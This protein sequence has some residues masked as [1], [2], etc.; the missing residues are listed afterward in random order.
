MKKQ[1]KQKYILYVGDTSLWQ[2]NIEYYIQEKNL[3]W[4]IIAFVSKSYNPKNKPETQYY[5]QIIVDFENVEDIIF[6]IDQISDRLVAAVNRG[7]RNIPYFQKIIP[8]LPKG[9]LVPSIDALTKATEKTAMRKAFWKYDKTITPKFEILEDISNEAIERVA[10]RLEFPVIVKPSGLAQAVLVQAA[11]YPAELSQILK[12]V[13]KKM[14]SSYAEMKGRGNP[15]ILVEEIIDGDQ[16]SIEAFV[17]DIG[18]VS[19]CPFIKYTTS[20]QKGFDDFFSYEQTTPATISPDSAQAAKAVAIKGIHA[21]GLRNSAAHIELIRQEQDW[22]IVEI[23][24]RLGGFRSMMY[25]ESFNI[26]L[27]VQDILNHMGKKLSLPR[28]KRGYTSVIKFFAKNEGII[29]KI[30]GIKKS[31]TLPSFHHITQKLKKGDRARFAK[32]GGNYVFRVTL[33]NADKSQF[34]E[35]KRKLEQM[36]HIETEKKSKK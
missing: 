9:L 12:D 11:H 23:G 24:P 29:T 31:Q 18:N 2:K 25:K 22:K 17:D 21:L 5:K 4:K 14:K 35:D 1:P 15:V 27:D 7:E 19:F 8:H 16:Y 30:T 26:N 28:K 34:I 3:N 20:A 6:N 13:S 36:V 32:N 33:F 10:K